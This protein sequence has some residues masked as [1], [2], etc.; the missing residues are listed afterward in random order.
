MPHRQPDRMPEGGGE[1]GKQSSC[2]APRRSVTVLS[3]AFCTPRILPHGTLSSPFYQTR[4]NELPA[5]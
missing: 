3:S 5:A 2:Q 1:T 4:P